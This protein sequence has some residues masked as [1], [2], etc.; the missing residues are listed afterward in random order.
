MPWDPKPVAQP[1]AAPPV[2]QDDPNEQMLSQPGDAGMP[3]RAP[4][5]IKYEH[6]K[7]EPRYENPYTMPTYPGSAITP[8]ARERASNLLQQQFGS[9]A[10]A[11][12]QAAGLP[13]QPRPLSLPGQQRAQQ[14][15]QQHQHQQQRA[16]QGYHQGGVGS[17]QHDGAGEWAELVAQARAGEADRE[18]V[19]GVLRA[20]LDAMTAD[21]DGGVFSSVSRAPKKDKASKAGRLPPVQ[22][23]PA[24]V[25]QA[26]GADSIEDEDAINSDLDDT[27]DDLDNEQVDDDGAMSEM[28]LCTWDK[29]NR[30]KNKVRLFES[31]GLGV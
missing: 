26:D 23:P 28:I 24:G 1:V 22:K 15:H 25:P 7:Q 18:Q 14:Q 4:P 29:V 16:P 9:Q 17:A 19:D 3:G 2:Y 5:E 30:V 27:D 11:S 13:Q 20:R 12:I 31:G 6:V 21:L 8:L 10:A